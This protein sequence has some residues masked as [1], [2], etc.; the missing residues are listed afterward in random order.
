M[1]VCLLALALAHVASG[2]RVPPK[3][4]DEQRA[5]LKLLDKLSDDLSTELKQ[6]RKDHAKS[7]C[8]YNAEIPTEKENIAK[9]TKAIADAEAALTEQRG[10]NQENGQKKVQL[11]KD[12]A[13][14]QQDTTDAQAARKEENDAFNT[15]K[16]N[17]EAMIGGLEEA[18]KVL[19]DVFEK[20]ADD[21]TSFLATGSRA[22]RAVDQAVAVLS[23]ADRA[24][25]KSKSL[26][27][28]IGVLEQAHDQRKKDLV[29][30][31]E[32]EK[33]KLE[34]HN[35]YLDA[36]AK[37]LKALEEDLGTVSGL[38]KN[39]VKEVEDQLKNKKDAE[40]RL[41]TAET[42]LKSHQDG[43]KLQ[44]ENF[45]AMEAEM[46]ATIAAVAEARKIIDGPEMARA[47]DLGRGFIQL[48]KRFAP[49]RRIPSSLLSAPA[50]G[51]YQS[52][53]KMLIGEIA[54]Y[55]KELDQSNKDEK[56][57]QDWCDKER[58][59]KKK[60]KTDSDDNAQLLGTEIGG[61]KTA[62]ET[63]DKNIKTEE[64]KKQ[65]AVDAIAKLE[66]D[67]E[68][69][70]AD[71]QQERAKFESAL[72]ALDLAIKVFK[73]LQADVG[74][75]KAQDGFKMATKKN[76]AVGDTDTEWKSDALKKGTG[77][78][79]KVVEELDK[80][81]KKFKDARDQAIKTEANNAKTF[82][83][84]KD[85]ELKNISDAEDAITDENSKKADNEKSKSDKE[86]DKESEEKNSKDIADYLDSI[87]PDCEFL[88]KNLAAR[89]QSRDDDKKA[90]EDAKKTLE[91]MMK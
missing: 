4:A 63:N 38:L 89:K 90:L 9:E 82:V 74:D 32:V 29:D 48:G 24:R 71:Y 8:F 11:E 6:L 72:T 67:R 45:A 60:E 3:V 86:E 65:K 54:K 43:Q 50:H 55:I 66:S 91:G 15:E 22:K 26:P 18:E 56:E 70:I 34:A 61:L 53:I 69:E 39:G 14:N 51:D 87:R 77:A 80:V 64:G 59:D 76:A 73:K 40:G 12:I 57:K 68:E 79:A 83:E 44:N 27:V 88:D 30:A 1:R 16:A 21:Y 25:V 52:A 75:S 37:Q 19:K 13:D 62:I 46:T 81:E 41:D 5:L 47:V 78:L 20:H 17:L 49:L 35:D 84:D 42:N 2:L 33:A 36:Q 58:K 85:A 31:E 23:A 10:K 28:I 7:S